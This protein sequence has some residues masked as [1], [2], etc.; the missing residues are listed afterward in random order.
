[1]DPAKVTHMTQNLPTLSNKLN[2]STLPTVSGSRF[3]FAVVSLTVLPIVL[4]C[5]LNGGV[6][7]LG[8]TRTQA[9]EEFKA[10][11]DFITGQ[12]FVGSRQDVAQL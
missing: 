12:V 9:R 8:F 10:K 11:P 2:L 3:R 5:D 7:N 1:M 6:S 4:A